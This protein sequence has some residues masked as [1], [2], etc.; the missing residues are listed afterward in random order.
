MAIRPNNTAPIALG[1]GTE[2]K[3]HVPSPKAR[4]DPSLVARK[5]SS[6]AAVL[7]N[8]EKPNEADGGVDCAPHEYDTVQP[9]AIW[10]I[11]MN[12]YSGVEPRESHPV[13]RVPR[14]GEFAADVRSNL[15]P[16]HCTMKAENPVVAS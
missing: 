5:I 9:V 16:S 11:M 6:D 12:P 14:S 15:I 3:L 10:F 4:T 7:S 2:L 8:S 13:E 1:S